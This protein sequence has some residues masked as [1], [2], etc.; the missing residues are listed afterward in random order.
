[1]P[2]DTP[3]LPPHSQELLRAARSGKLYKR[4]AATEEEDA[5][6]DA[7]GEKNEK[8][9]EVRS[10]GYSTRIWKPLPRNEERELVSHLAKR[11]KGTIMLPSKAVLSQT[12]GPTITRATV[13]KID[14]AGNPYEQ[15]MTLEEA[16]KVDGEIIS[17]SIVPAPTAAAGELPSQQ[18]TPVRKRQPPPRRKAKGPGRGRKKKLLPLPGKGAA[19]GGAAGDGSGGDVTQATQSDSVR[20]LVEKFCL[21][22]LSLTT[23][24][25]SSKKARTMLR[26]TK[27]AKWRTTQL[28][29]RTKRKVMM[30]RKARKAR[31]ETTI[32]KTTLRIVTRPPGLP[33]IK[34]R[35][36]R[37]QTCRRHPRLRKL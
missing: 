1:M 7:A 8:K 34:S 24:R 35:I 17:T 14:A 27:I 20:F 6:A 15:T 30:V 9:E 31:R 19:S 11:R 21:R 23:T 12:S 37:C 3:L 13:R 26:L 4:A 36:S 32:T 22:M 18:A 10:E 25:Y 2:K 5:D 16:Q 33:K 29:R 28:L